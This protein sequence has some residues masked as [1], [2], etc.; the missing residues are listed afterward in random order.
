MQCVFGARNDGGHVVHRMVVDERGTANI[1]TRVLSR[2]AQDAR[3]FSYSASP[4]AYRYCLEH[5]A[6]VCRWLI[7][8]LP[9]LLIKSSERIE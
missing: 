8:P 7:C 5:F 4:F 1:A 6:P 2:I 3:V 9:L